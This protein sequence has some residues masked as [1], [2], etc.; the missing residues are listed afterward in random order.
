MDQVITQDSHLE[1]G[2]EPN[3]EEEGVLETNLKEDERQSE[4]KNANQ[5]SDIDKK[6]A[7]VENADANKT[8]GRGMTGFMMFVKEQRAEIK[9]TLGDKATPTSITKT[10][11]EIWRSLNLQEKE[12]W[13]KKAKEYKKETPKS[14]EAGEIDG[15]ADQSIK[16]L[17]PISK[18]RE[19]VKLDPE[20]HNISAQAVRMIAKATELFTEDLSKRSFDCGGRKR[21]RLVDVHHIIHSVEPQFGF[22]VDDFAT[23]ATLEAKGQ[24]AAKEKRKTGTDVKKDTEVAQTSKSISSYFQ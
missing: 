12:S 10:A 17:L 18:I 19:I 4:N 5:A 24:K 21:L 2:N 20:V 23:P 8:V 11:G 1:S 6:A 13:N 22:L 7:K 9:A 3:V 16:S 14:A 15:N